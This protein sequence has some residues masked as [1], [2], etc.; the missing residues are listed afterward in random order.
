VQTSSLSRS[1]PNR[2]APQETHEEQKKVTLDRIHELR[3]IALKHQGSH[4]SADYILEC[5]DEIDRVQEL[6]CLA[7][8]FGWSDYRS[9]A[10][11]FSQLKRLA[12]KA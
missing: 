5:L 6:Y 8:D 7:L 10:I 3:Q 11:A 2:E 4:R 9:K 12:E 1:S